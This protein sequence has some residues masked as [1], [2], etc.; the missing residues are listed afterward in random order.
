MLAGLGYIAAGFALGA[1]KSVAYGVKG[2]KKHSLHSVAMLGLD[3]LS[4]EVV[5]RTGV[6][7]IGLRGVANMGPE[8]ARML[9]A[10]AFGMGHTN[11]IDAA[12]GGYLY[13]RA[14]DAGGLGLSTMAH[15]AHNLG[16]VFLSR[17]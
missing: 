8:T 16:V 13:S 3:A 15:L 10:L 5:Y 2:P 14:Y 17:S 1:A 12:V 4:E 11:P 7:R 6:E 9:G